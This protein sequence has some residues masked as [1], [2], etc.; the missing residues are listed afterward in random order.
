MNRRNFLS[1]L[2]GGAAGAIIAPRKEYFFLNGLFRPDEKIVNATIEQYSDYVNFSDF[3]LW[4]DSSALQVL[5]RNLTF[6]E[7]HKER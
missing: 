7:L 3:I 5:R 2:A 6:R 1:T 4:Y